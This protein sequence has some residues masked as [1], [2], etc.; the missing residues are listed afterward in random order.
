MSHSH[1]VHR[2]VVV[3]S[4]H[5]YSLTDICCY[6]VCLFV[7]LLLS[8]HRHDVVMLVWLLRPLMVLLCCRCTWCSGSGHVK[9]AL[10]QHWRLSKWTKSRLQRPTGRWPHLAARLSLYRTFTGQVSG[11]PV[12][13]HTLRSHSSY[14]WFS[15]NHQAFQSFNTLFQWL[16]TASTWLHWL[17]HFTPM[18]FNYTKY[19]SYNTSTTLISYSSDTWLHWLVTPLI[20]DCTD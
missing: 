11:T 9:T 10:Q 1:R 8:K 19:Y 6:L 18:I 20:L 14:V 7:C 16:F 2:A 4:G 15:F 3:L 12:T 17:L 13:F 5:C